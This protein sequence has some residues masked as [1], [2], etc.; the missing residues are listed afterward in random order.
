MFL[1]V[2]T[3]LDAKNHGGRFY[4][5]QIG[6]RQKHLRQ[7]H[8]MQ[9]ISVF[10]LLNIVEPGGFKSQLLQIKTG[11]GKSWV[12]AATA[13]ILALLGFSV[14][15]A[16]FSDYLSQRDKHQFGKLF[17]LFGVRY[18][19]AYDIIGSFME[20]L[21][22]SLG[23]TRSLAR[24]LLKNESITELKKSSPSKKILFLDE[25]DVFFSEKFLGKTY[26]PGLRIMDSDFR[27]LLTHLWEERDRYAESDE[28]EALEKIGEH[29][30]MR[31]FLEKYPN[32]QY[33]KE[34]TVKTILSS[35][36]SVKSDLHPSYIVHP[37]QK[38]ENQ[39]SSSCFNYTE[40]IGYKDYTT[41]NLDFLTYYSY[42]T[43]FSYLKESKKFSEWTVNSHVGFS[44]NSGYLSY[45]LLPNIYAY[46][47]GVS[48]TLNTFSTE[49]K[50]VLGSYDIHTMTSMPSLFTK[51]PVI[52]PLAA[53]VYDGD[54]QE[55]KGYFF[56]IKDKITR[57]INLGRAVLVVFK[58][59]ARIEEFKKYI[60][61]HPFSLDRVDWSELTE[62][63]DNQTRDM[64]ISLAA[65]TGRIT[66][67]TKVFG[68]GSDFICHDQKLIGK[69]WSS[70]HSD[71]FFRN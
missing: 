19:I 70:C 51:D 69:W 60:Q 38:L 42:D 57:M 50:G 55:D 24:Q 1:A 66:L 44:V 14:D 23:D 56:N 63:T 15:V 12:T 54:I 41:G 47:L 32:A 61:S 35:L 34:K 6:E 49:E 68:R 10:L 9:V 5:L 30:D 43:D 28:K 37:K 53:D 18:Q 22:S 7:P 71:L 16:C 13:V 58:T 11:E 25:V 45:A 26:I 3:H 27:S 17:D 20:Q 8:P 31:K 33:F 21:M 48:G 2:A 52:H 36:K 46:K 40:G 4:S 67:L 62:A 65:T 64:F 29:A 39:S 59:D